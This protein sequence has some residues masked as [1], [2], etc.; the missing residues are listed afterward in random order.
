[1]D[2]KK[3]IGHELHKVRT[4]IL[5]GFFVRATVCFQMSIPEENFR[6]NKNI[7]VKIPGFLYEMKYTLKNIFF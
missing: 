6:L 4:E 1:M 5:K 3:R 2:I 7:A